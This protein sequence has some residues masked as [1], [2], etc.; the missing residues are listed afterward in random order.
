[1]S[2]IKCMGNSSRDV[3]LRGSWEF[4]FCYQGFLVCPSSLHRQCLGTI[5]S[6]NGR[7]VAWH[8]FKDARIQREILG[9]AG[10]AC[11]AL[12]EAPRSLFGLWFQYG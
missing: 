8:T 11:K 3:S 9:V 2:Q 5:R 6:R 7:G 12:T 1:M 4:F 10:R